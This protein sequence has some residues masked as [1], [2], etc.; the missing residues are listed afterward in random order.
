Q[1]SMFGPFAKAGEQ[2]KRCVFVDEQSKKMYAYMMR[3]TKEI[4][5]NRKKKTD[6][7]VGTNWHHVQRQ[8][9]KIIRDKSVYNDSMEK[10]TAAEPEENE[11]PY[12]TE[13]MRDVR[14]VFYNCLLARVHSAWEEGAISARTAHVI[15]RLI[16]HGLDEGGLT[17]DDFTE[18]LKSIDASS[19]IIKA[20]KL[21]KRANDWIF[22]IW[23]FNCF[24]L[25]SSKKVT[26][27]DVLK[28]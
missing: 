24:L 19:I 1:G 8:T 12:E 6:Y 11:R 17:V 21:L 7:L 9:F 15:I 3:K 14:S 20:N 22:N 10:E 4:V 2:T 25:P 28:G 23:L 18:H 13:Q 16:D 27:S 5:Q 26:S